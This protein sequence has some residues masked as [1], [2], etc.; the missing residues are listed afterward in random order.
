VLLF[1]PTAFATSEVEK[2]FFTAYGIGVEMLRCQQKS[3]F[4]S[5]GFRRL[6]KAVL[7]QPFSAIP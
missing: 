1:T 7:S 2:V 3:A 6:R 4:V 5:D